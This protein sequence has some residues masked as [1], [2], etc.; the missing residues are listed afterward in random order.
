MSDEPTPVPL[1]QL[2][3]LYGRVYKL[4]YVLDRHDWD[5]IETLGR[6]RN[7]RPIFAVTQPTGLTQE[8][9]NL[10]MLRLFELL[11]GTFFAPEV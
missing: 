5:A 6:V 9:V 1:G 2:H 7:A 8:Q 11:P 10:A 3:A 4:D